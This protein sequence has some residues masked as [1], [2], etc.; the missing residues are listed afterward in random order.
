TYTDTS[1]F[2]G[3]PPRH[4]KAEKPIGRDLVALTDY[5]AARWVRDGYVTAIDKGNVPHAK[6]LVPELQSINY[7]PHRNLT[8][9]WQAGGIGIG[10]DPRKTGRKLNS[11]QDFFDPKF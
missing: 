7:D 2:S 4:L 5:M 8:P 9:S 3:E 1:D 11:I 6:N 10:Y